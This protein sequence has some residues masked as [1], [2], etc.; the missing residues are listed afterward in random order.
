MLT[1]FDIIITPRIDVRLFTFYLSLWL[2]RACEVQL[3]HVG[4]NNGSGVRECKCLSNGCWKCLNVPY[5]G[6]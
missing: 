6:L 2:V 3:S 5:V 1:S 4:K